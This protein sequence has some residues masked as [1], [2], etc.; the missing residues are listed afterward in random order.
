MGTKQMGQ[1]DLGTG[2]LLDGLVVLVTK[3]KINGFAEGWFAVAN[4]AGAIFAKSDLG[5]GEHRVLW[6]LFSHLDF[7]NHLA[8][9]Q[10]EIAREL[11]MQRQHVQRAIK[12]L[13]ELEVLVE[14]KKNGQN[15]TYKLNPEFGWKGSGDNH[16]KALDDHRKA[17]MRAAKITGVVK[18][19]PADT[20]DPK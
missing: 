13:M 19:P 12:R 18:T 14:G 9:N 4:Q 8:I 7:E 11:G 16:R 17:R 5:L 10:A 20:K 15:R 2:E 1:M 3:K 6:M